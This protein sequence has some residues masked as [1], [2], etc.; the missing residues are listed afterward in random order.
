M[1]PRIRGR[2]AQIDAPGDKDDNKFVYEITIW[3]LAGETQICDPILFGPYE[4]EAIA[5]ENGRIKVKDMC[6]FIE[7]EET[8]EISGRFLDLKNGAIMRPWDDHA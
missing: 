1:I 5:K 3:N 2:V 6:N 8:G 4:T 7:K